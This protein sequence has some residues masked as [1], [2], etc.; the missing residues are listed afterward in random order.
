M[1]DCVTDWRVWLCLLRGHLERGTAEH[2]NELAVVVDVR[3]VLVLLLVGVPQHGAHLGEGGVGGDGRDLALELPP[4]RVAPRAAARHAHLPREEAAL[5][6]RLASQQAAECLVLS[7]W[8]HA[9]THLVGMIR[10]LCIVD[11]VGPCCVMLDREGHC[12]RA[13]A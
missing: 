10:W 9:A 8:H 4:C 12:P 6:Q 13:P 3:E 2:A 11:N 7:V 5:P 1:T